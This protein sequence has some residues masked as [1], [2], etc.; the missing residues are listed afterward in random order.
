MALLFLQKG[1][2]KRRRLYY[3]RKEVKIYSALTGQKIP[4]FAI[5]RE[6]PYGARQ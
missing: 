3:N 2:D 1:I 6:L 4:K 5:I